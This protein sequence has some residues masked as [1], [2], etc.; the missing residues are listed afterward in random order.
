VT[1]KEDVAQRNY[2]LNLKR[3]VIT[4][5]TALA[6][7]VAAGFLF[8]GMGMAIA[9]GGAL[10]LMAG[11]G[12]AEI[13]TFKEKTALKIDEEMMQNYMHPRNTR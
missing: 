12:V 9:V 10:G 7:A 2:N 5:L 3:M 13:V 8:S 11:G 6:G 1:M 4:G